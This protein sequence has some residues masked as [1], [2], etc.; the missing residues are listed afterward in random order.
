MPAGRCSRSTLTSACTAWAAGV[1]TLRNRRPFG[2]NRR[3]K[4]LAL[5]RIRTTRAC[6]RWNITLRSGIGTATAALNMPAAPRTS[7]PRALPVGYGALG[8]NNTG[9]GVETLP[10]SGYGAGFNPG[11]LGQLH[12]RYQGHLG[13]HARLLVQALQRSEGP[14]ANWSAVLLRDQDKPGPATAPKHPSRRALTRPQSTICSSLPSAT[15]CRKQPVGWPV[16]RR[17]PDI[18]PQRIFCHSV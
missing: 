4:R 8:F 5:R 6:S 12:W 11:S 18:F 15:T 2:C 17:L 16:L 3:S 9:C 10:R 7:T 14:S 13:R 1:W